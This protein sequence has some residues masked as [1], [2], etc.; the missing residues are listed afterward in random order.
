VLAAT[1]TRPIAGCSRRS[2]PHGASRRRSCPTGTRAM[3]E[4]GEPRVGA[5]VPSGAARRAHAGPRRLR[6]G[7]AHPRGAG[8]GRRDRHAADVGR[9]ERRPGALP[10]ARRRAPSDQAVHA[11]GA[12]HAVLL[13]L[14]QSAEPTRRSRPA[15]RDASASGCT[16]WSR[17]TTPSTSA[18][19]AAAGKDGAHPDRHVNGRRAV[20]ALREPPISTSR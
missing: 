11:V 7:R 19:Q 10:H 8:A 6:G 15:A 14:G 3:A 9:D 20:E 13:A 17:R 2:S 18:D 4:L 16:S 1:T 5:H 12:A